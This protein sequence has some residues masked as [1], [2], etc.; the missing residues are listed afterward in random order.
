MLDRLKNRKIPKRKGKKGKKFKS[1]ENMSRAR[2]PK[3]SS[4]KRMSKNEATK[5]K[6][7]DLESPNSLVINQLSRE[8]KKKNVKSNPAIKS[9]AFTSNKH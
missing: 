6:I 7:C 1:Y 8:K 2:W 5:R 9:G 4:N 3:K